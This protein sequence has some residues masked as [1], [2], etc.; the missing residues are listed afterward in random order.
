MSRVLHLFPLSI[1]YI[2]SS[3]SSCPTPRTLIPNLRTQV[4]YNQ[5]SLSLT[6][7][8]TRR[9]PP[10]SRSTLLVA[11]FEHHRSASDV[12]PPCR[13]PVTGDHP[14]VEHS[15]AISPVPV[16][17]AG[18]LIP[19]TAPTSPSTAPQTTTYFSSAGHNCSHPEPPTSF[20]PSHIKATTTKIRNH[21]YLRQYQRPP[22]FTSAHRHS[23]APTDVHQRPPAFATAS[24]PTRPVHVFVVLPFL[25]CRL[26]P[27]PTRTPLRHVPVTLSRASDHQHP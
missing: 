10:P 13:S 16:D 3:F 14:R 9:R 19:S 26:N 8:L 5:E 21:P 18:T 1:F 27:N 25:I 15:T 11:F 4:R 20:L 12:A 7:T 17:L 23:P 6:L 2:Y 22:A 24:S